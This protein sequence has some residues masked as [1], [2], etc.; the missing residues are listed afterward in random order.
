MVDEIL[1]AFIKDLLDQI[2]MTIRDEFLKFKKDDADEKN[3]SENGYLNSKEALLLLKISR[4]TL[5]KLMREGIIPF[6]RIG[7]RLLF[8]ETEIKRNLKSFNDKNEIR[9]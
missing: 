2:Q 4:P 9:R 5:F 3:S 8:D 1:K 6:K 7:R